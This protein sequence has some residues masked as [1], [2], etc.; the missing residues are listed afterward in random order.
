MPGDAIF[1]PPIGPTIAVDGEVRRPA[2]YE[3]K[4]ERA[5]A[6]LVS[7]AGG[8]TPNANR[9]NLS[10]SGSCR[11]AARPWRTSTS[12]TASQTAVRDGD[13]LR[14]PPNLDQLENSVRLAGNV[15]S[16][17]ALPVDARH[18]APDLSPAP[19]LVKPMSDLNYILMRREPSPNVD[20]AVRSRPICSRPGA[21]RTGPRTSRSRR[22]T[23]CTSSISRRAASTSST[24]SSRR[25]RRRCR[26]IRPG[27]SC[28]SAVRCARRASIRSS[29]AC[30]QRSAARRRRAQRGGVRHR[31]RAHA[32]RDRQRR[33]P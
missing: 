3:I 1:V 4:G 22:A 21:S 28:E 32:L 11:I 24:R 26:R 13:V 10:S 23:R 25:S 30:G 18:A 6:E 27:P 16:A 14:V 15:L 5:V 29:A 7:L 2:I 9:T 31:R 33:I 19:E 12:V 20:I 8:L 17:R